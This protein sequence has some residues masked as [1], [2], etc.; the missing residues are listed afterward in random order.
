M[1]KPKSID[2]LYFGGSAAVGREEGGVNWSIH[3]VFKHIPVDNRCFHLVPGML[4]HS[5]TVAR[6]CLVL[7][8]ELAFVRD[9]RYLLVAVA[10]LV[11]CLVGC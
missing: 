6:G 10:C 7:D 4:F 11:G 5:W 3:G 9:V 2:T 8:G 1:G